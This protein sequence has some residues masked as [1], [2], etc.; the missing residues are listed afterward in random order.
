[1]AT[2]PEY[3]E[4]VFDQIDNRWNKRYRKMF[5]EYMVYVNDKPILLVCDNTVY[6]KKLDCIK[7]FIKDEESGFPY[8][9]AKE[10][11]LVDVE[12]EESFS[13]IIE[14][15]EKVIKVP[16]KKKRKTNM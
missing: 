14:K 2:T 9:G 16:V 4:F 3:I 5:G 13:N 7:P 8:N 12:D 10:H 11:Y 6:A 15:L 1:M